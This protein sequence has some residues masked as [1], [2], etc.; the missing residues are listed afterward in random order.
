MELIEIGKIAKS[1]E[2]VMRTLDTNKK[3]EI[4]LNAADQLLI[5]Y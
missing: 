2:S 4:L 1:A 3:N 5:N